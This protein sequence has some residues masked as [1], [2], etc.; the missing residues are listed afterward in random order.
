M[1]T[2][3]ITVP[4]GVGLIGRAVGF[5]EVPWANPAPGGFNSTGG[6]RLLARPTTP[7][8]NTTTARPHAASSSAPSNI[9]PDAPQP[10]PPADYALPPLFVLNAGCTVRGLFIDYDRMPYPT[11]RELQDPASPFFYPNFTTAR[12]RFY[13]D[14]LPA[15]GPTFLILQGRYVVVEDVDAY[16]FRDF[17]YMAPGAGQSHFRRLHGWGYGTFIAVEFAADVLTFDTLHYII[18]SGPHSVGPRPPWCPPLPAPPPVWPVCTGNFSWL[19]AIVAAHPSNVGLWLGR[20]DGYVARELFFFGINTAMRF[21]YSPDCPTGALVSPITGQPLPPQD[22]A[23]G[24]WGAVSNILVDQCLVGLHFVWPQPLTNRFSNVQIHPSFS[25]LAPFP[26]ANGTG[27][28]QG[29]SRESAVLVDATHTTAN[30]KG[31]PAVMMLTNMAIATFADTP[32]FGPLSFNLNQSNGRVFLLGGDALFEVT[33][34][35]CNNVANASSM[36]WAAS[37]SAQASLRIRSPILNGMPRDDI[38]AIVG[39]WPL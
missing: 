27:S 1:L 25:L 26:A 35:S 28:L 6:P 18:N 22:P 36:L 3:T 2:S 9:P 37:A 21:G 13:A 20:S 39:S 29:V 8:P 4:P 23:T 14:H 17:I 11:D 10:P 19:P 38:H 24:P 33:Q 30:N 15:I 5:P 16:G 31:L 34:F 32:R 7:P 12:Q